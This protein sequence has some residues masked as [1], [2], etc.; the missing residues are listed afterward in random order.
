MRFPGRIAASTAAL[1]IVLGIPFLGIAVHL[2][3]RPGAARVRARAPGRRRAARRLPALSRQPVT[4]AVEGGA[5]EAARVAREAA[6]GAGRRG[7]RARRSSWRGGVY[8]VDVVSAAPPLDERSQDLVRDLRDLDG[9]ALVTGA[10]RRLPRPPGQP[11]ATTCRSCSRSS[12]VVTIVVLFVMTGSVILP[13]KQIL[14]ERARAERRVRHPRAGLPGR[15]PRGPARLHAARAASSRPSR[16][17]CSRSCSACPPT[18]ACSCCRASRRRAT[19]ATRTPSAVAIGLERTGRIV[20]AAALLFCIAIGAF[21]TSQ[22]VFIKELGARHGAGRPDR[23]DD[24]PRP[25]GARR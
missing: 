15:A 3:R 21:V 11:R 5:G 7:G 4:L 25:A 13:V 24:H 20:T 18:T 6:A 17:S 16:C 23:R 9:D 12:P 14:D 1:L 19:R 22:I 8:A 10:D 2:G